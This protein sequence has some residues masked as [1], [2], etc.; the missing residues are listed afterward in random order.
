MSSAS[1]QLAASP[2]ADR[3]LSDSSS[4]VDSWIHGNAIISRSLGPEFH[5]FSDTELE[6]YSPGGSRPATPIHSDTEYE[7]RVGRRRRRN[8]FVSFLFLHT[9]T[10]RAGRPAARQ[11]RLGQ[12]LG[13]GHAT[14]VALGRTAQSARPQVHVA[15]DHT[16]RHARR[17][18]RCR[19]RRAPIRRRKRPNSDVV[20]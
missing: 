17:R 18:R 5:F 11:Q 16:R 8:L 10:M 2:V 4:R 20:R 15:V 12:R 13:Q 3:K 6:G 7:V 14:V 19:H 9:F 1:A